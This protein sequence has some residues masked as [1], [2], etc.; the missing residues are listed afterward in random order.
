[1]AGEIYFNNLTGK[2]DWGSIIDQIIKIKSF[3]LQRLSAEA[4]QIQ[5]K[6]SSIQKLLDAVKGLS[7][8]FEKLKADDLFKGKRVDSSDSSVLTATASENT[9]NVMLNVDVLKLAQREAL[10]TLNGVNE[11][12]IP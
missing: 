6:Q 3:P 1:M 10:A 4:Q 5:A 2:F 7:Q 11:L 8:V 12:K 9:P